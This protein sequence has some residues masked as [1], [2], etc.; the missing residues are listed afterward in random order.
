MY[1]NG[2][3]RKEVVPQDRHLGPRLLSW[4]TQ[5]SLSEK[6]TFLADSE[7][8]QLVIPVLYADQL[9]SVV[10]D[11]LST[12]YER[13]SL[14]NTFVKI[15]P[16][17]AEK[18]RTS[19]YQR[20]EDNLISLMIHQAALRGAMDDAAQQYI[21]ACRYYD[22]RAPSDKRNPI[23]LARSWNRLAQSILDRRSKHNLS[24]ELFDEIISFGKRSSRPWTWHPSCLQLYHPTRP[25]HEP[26]R[27]LL[28]ADGFVTR[29]TSVSKG[30]PPLH[31]LSVI[32][33]D[34]ITLCESQ[35]HHKDAEVLRD[36]KDSSLSTS[37]PL[38]KQSTPS[39]KQT[40]TRPS[41]DSVESFDLAWT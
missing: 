37:S 6:Y 40:Q 10:W 38:E 15:S 31:T 13:P 9:E 28:G 21:Q 8:L 14:S 27:P 11:M 20:A 18:S 26:L 16:H 32:I 25:S 33:D 1:L 35:G 22:S 12:L 24:P 39:S 3:K 7:V 4:Y 36:I 17:L 2:L 30:G 5:M 23:K 29:T 41:N 34:A 19:L